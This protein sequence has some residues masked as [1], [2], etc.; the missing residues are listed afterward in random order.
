MTTFDS[1]RRVA[2][3]LIG[4]ISAAGLYIADAATQDTSLAPLAVLPVLAITFAAGWVSGLIFSLLAGLAFGTV[5]HSPANVL[6]NAVV[7]AASFTVVVG[8]FT[9]ARSWYARSAAYQAE[10]GEAKAFHDA[11]FVDKQRLG[12]RWRAH[13]IHAPLR[14]TG[15]DFYEILSTKAEGAEVFIADV[16]GK[17]MR[18][19]MLLSALKTLWQASPSNDPAE[20][21]TFLNEQLQIVSANEMFCTALHAR[22][23]ADGVVQYA[24]AGHERPLISRNGTGIE[25]LAGGGIVLG[26]VDDP[27]YT[28]ARAQ[29]R[30][31]DALLLFTDGLA[32][33]FQSG[34]L[35]VADCFRSFDEMRWKIP[36]MQRRD[37]VLAILLEYA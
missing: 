17:G 5:G 4:L 28:S 22:L 1:R 32:E 14:D 9:A 10:I 13:V 37:D 19:S 2:L 24:N 29:L 3:T 15:G 8:L 23:N 11:L 7:L 21:L 25:E 27:G 31:G 26:I 6:P 30:P 12:S 20:K 33:L 18:A 35:D 36:T 34:Q 16:S